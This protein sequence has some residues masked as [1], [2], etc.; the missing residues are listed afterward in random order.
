MRLRRMPMSCSLRE[1]TRRSS[2]QQ[3]NGRSRAHRLLQARQPALVEALE[4]E[5][6]GIATQVHRR[7]DPRSRQA[8]HGEH[9]DLGAPHQ[10]GTAR[11]RARQLH[12][13]FLFLIAHG[14]LRQPTD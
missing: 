5:A 6:D 14:P 12:Q 8:L 3:A 7:G 9:D 4:P 13:A 2:V 10:T 1:A 11:P